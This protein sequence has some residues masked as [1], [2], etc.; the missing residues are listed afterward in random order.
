M[1]ISIKLKFLES[2]SDNKSLEIL[3]V[4][5]KGDLQREKEAQK[6]SRG[7]KISVDDYL[8]SRR[9]NN[10]PRGSDTARQTITHREGRSK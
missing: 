3:R 9:G 10:T 4:M 8:T 2:L 5:T 7:E 1:E 6:S